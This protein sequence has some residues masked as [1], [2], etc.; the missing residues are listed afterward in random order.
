MSLCLGFS[1]DVVVGRLASDGWMDG[2]KVI[3][4]LCQY[5]PPLSL[6]LTTHSGWQESSLGSSRDT[7]HNADRWPTRRRGVCVRKRE[8]DG[9]G[10]YLAS[11]FSLEN[12]AWPWLSEETC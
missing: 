3:K 7:D 1:A 6:A 5:S 10:K 12:G 4:S 9:L 2:E 8:M 11:H